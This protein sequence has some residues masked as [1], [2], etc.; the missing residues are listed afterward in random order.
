MRT[1]SMSFRVTF[2]PSHCAM[3][4]QALE[5]T[6]V[7]ISTL[8]GTQLCSSVLRNDSLSVHIDSVG[9]PVPHL[10]SRPSFLFRILTCACGGPG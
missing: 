6:F 2:A 9:Q 4:V 3:H 10:C 8:I 7:V 1:L 5:Y